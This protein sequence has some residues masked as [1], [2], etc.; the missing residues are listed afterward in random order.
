[1]AI[2]TSQF[3]LVVS[4]KYMAFTKFS[5]AI[6]LQIQIARMAVFENIQSHTLLDIYKAWSF[7]RF[8]D[9]KIEAQGVY[10]MSIKVTHFC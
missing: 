1:M 3:F 4:L 8:Q 9:L 7:V 2:E 5:W 6:D 10:E